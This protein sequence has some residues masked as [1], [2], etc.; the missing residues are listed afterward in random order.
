MG[1]ADPADAE[2]DLT[3]VEAEDRGVREV[4]ISVRSVFVASAVDPEIVIVL[5][6]F[7]MRQEHDPDGESPETRLVA[8]KHLACTANRATTMVDAELGGN[9]EDVVILLLV[10][11]LLEHTCRLCRLAEP[12]GTKL[13]FAVVVEL[14]V[15]GLLDHREHL[16]DRFT[17]GGGD[18]LPLRDG[19]PSF[20]VLGKLTFGD[21]LIGETDAGEQLAQTVG[22]LGDSLGLVTREVAVIAGDL[23]VLELVGDRQILE[24]GECRSA[25]CFGE[26]VAVF[27]DAL[28]ARVV[29]TELTEN[30]L[31]GVGAE[32]VDL[33]DLTGGCVCLSNRVHL[34]YLQFF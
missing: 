8:S 33:L 10:A 13:T 23:L 32:P 21:L 29:E 34:R 19:E 31:D 1:I 6:P 14:A 4:A 11:E 16:L 7:R 2:P 9:D 26:F 27:D 12:V 18:R 17:V 25:D 22:L 20:G 3:V 24:R 28:C 30:L 5:E 15:A